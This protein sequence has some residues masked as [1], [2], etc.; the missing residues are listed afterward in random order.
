MPLAVAFLSK[1]E[2]AEAKADLEL[3]SL[4]EQWLD[5]RVRGAGVAVLDARPPRA[6]AA[7]G[8]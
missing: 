7:R 4:F 5:I 2:V 1:L 6:T 3:P 8:R